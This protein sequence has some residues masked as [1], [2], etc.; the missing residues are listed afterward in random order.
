MAMRRGAGLAQMADLGLRKLALRDC[1]ERELDGVVAVDVRASRTWTTGHGPA[2]I[3]VTAV[4]APVSGSK[5][6]LIPSF[7]PRM[8]FMA[9]HALH[10]S[11][12]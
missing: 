9:E 5:T 3:T 10:R 11:R 8:P 12:A 4:I 1:V 2:S 6:W 7:L